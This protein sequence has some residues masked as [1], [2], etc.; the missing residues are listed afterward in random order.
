MKKIFITLGILLTFGVNVFANTSPG[1]I[2]SIPASSEN[3]QAISTD[4]IQNN[5]AIDLMLQNY[6]DGY[7]SI[8]FISTAEIDIG[9]GGVMLQN[10]NG[11]VRLMVANSSVTAVNSTMIDTGSI[12][13][14]STYYLYAYASSVTATTFS[15]IFSASSSQP[16]G[17][18]Y[19][20][21]LGSF[22]T[23]A[24]S[25][26]SS[27][28]N[29]VYPQKGLG[30]WSSSNTFGVVYQAATDGFVLVKQSPDVGNGATPVISI[31]TDSNNPPTTVRQ[32]NAPGDYYG[33]QNCFM[34][35]VRKGDY[36]EVTA[37]SGSGTTVYWI[38]IGS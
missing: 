17:I 3:P 30:S 24:S 11:S 37:Q 22:K 9:S 10:S 8:T 15:V 1:W 23:D 16:S 35:P 29:N 27:V 33:R 5:T 26:F 28:T 6:R 7:V 13:A 18:T 32:G 4:V 34:C 14:S 31:L 21:Q 36:W 20:Q 2:K 25:N 38:P 19:Y 12:S